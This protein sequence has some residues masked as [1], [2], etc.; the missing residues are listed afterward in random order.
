MSFIKNADFIVSKKDMGKICPVFSK[1]FKLSKQVKKVT[2]EISA[3]GVYEAFINEKRIGDF[4]LA[5][6][7]TAYQARLQYQTYDITELVNVEN[8]VEISLGQGWFVGNLGFNSEKINKPKVD[9]PALIAAISIEYADGTNEVILSD[10]SWRV[11]PSEIILSQIYNGEIYDARLEKERD[12]QE[13][14]VYTAYSKNNLINQEGEIIKEIE[15]IEAKELIITPKG[16]RVIDFGQEVTGY[17]EFAVQG[18]YGALI[19]IDHAEVLDKDGN[20]YNENYRSARSQATYICSGSKSSYKAHHTFY[21]FRYIRLTNWSGEIKKENFKAVVVHSQM[22]RTGHFECSDPMVNKLYSNVIWGHRGNFLDVPTDCPQRDERLGWTGDANIFCK[23][24]MYNYDVEKFFKKWLRDLRFEQLKNGGVPN[25]IPDVF[26][27]RDG[28]HSSSYWG[29]AACVVPW[30]LYLAYGDKDFLAQQ[31][32]SMKKYVEYMRNSG[33]S[34]FLFDQDFHFSDWMALDGVYDNH[35]NGTDMKYKKMLA[36]GAF[37]HSTNILIKAGK[38]LGKDMS[39][40][41]ALLAGIKKAY[42]E[43]YIVDNDLLFKTQAQY[44]I[45]LHFNL[46]EDKPLYAKRLVKLIKDNGNRLNTGFVGTA[47]LMDALSENGYAD[48]AYSLLLQTEFP[49]WLFSVRMGATTIWEHWDCIKEDGTMWSKSMNSFNHYAYGVVASWMYGT[50]A[51]INYDE[52]SPAYEKVIIK[53]IADD[54][55][56]WVKASLETRKGLIKSAWK[57]ENNEIVYEISI[58]KNSKATV[59]IDDKTY[60]VEAGDHV[61]KGV[62]KK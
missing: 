46:V 58:P 42:N 28:N 27:S 3:M 22:K 57:H 47:Y 17:V 20:F 5:P 60:D 54:R 7:W 26:D 8:F 14:G 43:N 13:V 10:E 51:G 15:T 40:Y 19:E 53:P 52:E 62:C 31:F 4:I 36:T 50:M 45:A 44:V 6:G 55:I 29:D 21:G 48:V 41:Q 59:I 23:T 11:S 2:A 61:F 30:E 33:S 39:A 18:E 1:A 25:V 37:A 38:A 49:S 12:W 34:E 9:R 32:D 56:D 35:D 24:A 16:E